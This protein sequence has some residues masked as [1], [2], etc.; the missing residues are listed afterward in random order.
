[1]PELN[2]EKA[3]GLGIKNISSLVFIYFKGILQHFRFENWTI[4]EFD[5]WCHEQGNYVCFQ[6]QNFKK[7]WI[8]NWKLKMKP[9]ANAKVIGKLRSW[10]DME[11]KE[12]FSYINKY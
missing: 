9:L 4:G 1:M 5:F 7:I 8:G 2:F 11:V 6:I 10:I 12:M 3:D